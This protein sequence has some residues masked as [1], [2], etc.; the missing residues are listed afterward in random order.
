[1][2][3]E[4]VISIVEFIVNLF[5]GGFN[6]IG[7]FFAN[8][9]GQIISGFISFAKVGSKI[10][11]TLFGTDITK[12]FSD[13]QDEVLSWGKNENSVTFERDFKGINGIEL[14]KAW[15]ASYGVGEQ[16]DNKVS[17]MFGVGNDPSAMF[18]NGINPED[19][20]RHTFGGSYY[21]RESDM[22]AYT[23]IAAIFKQYNSSW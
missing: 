14:G 17:G 10:F 16:F 11:D 12:S 8:I 9:M 4:P 5:N 6:G 20:A 3:V 18:A 15:D 2:L 7:G 19:F 22:E 1:M 23:R 21:G 13:L